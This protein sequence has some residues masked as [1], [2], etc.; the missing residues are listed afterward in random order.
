VTPRSRAVQGQP[1]SNVIVLCQ[2]IAYGRF[3]FWSLIP[4][5][6]MSPTSRYFTGNYHTVTSFY[7]LRQWRRVVGQKRHV[8]PSAIR[9]GR[10]KRGAVFFAKWNIQIFCELCWGRD[11]HGR[12]NHVRRTMHI[13]DVISSVLKMHQNLRRLGLYPDPTALPQTP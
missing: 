11:G 6:Y 4:T 10:R 9:E 8:P 5:L 1:R 7:D 3:P 13:L 12:T 2:S